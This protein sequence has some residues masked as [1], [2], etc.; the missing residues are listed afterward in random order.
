MIKNLQDALSI[1]GKQIRHK[2]PGINPWSVSFFFFF[3]PLRTLE[4][5]AKCIQLLFKA[6]LK[7]ST[8]LR[9]QCFTLL[10]VMWLHPALSFL[11]SLTYAIMTSNDTTQ[12]FFSQ[13][14]AAVTI[15]TGAPCFTQSPWT[16]D[17]KDSFGL[18]W[19]HRFWTLLYLIYERVSSCR[20][21]L[22]K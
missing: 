19:F 14:G 1:T 15:E 17:T 11:S 5:E 3:F 12:K 13:C 22:C 10:P 16:K 8:I 21:E 9:E 7:H 6:K 18:K 2:C 4:L 20:C